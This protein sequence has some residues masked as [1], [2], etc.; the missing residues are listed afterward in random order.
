[1]TTLGLPTGTYHDVTISI[2]RLPGLIVCAKFDVEAAKSPV[3]ETPAVSTTSP[4]AV[5]TLS[6]RR[7]L[8][9]RV[10]FI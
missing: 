8:Y 9:E 3:D 1:M 6:F 5:V 4:I 2:E 7:S 10:D